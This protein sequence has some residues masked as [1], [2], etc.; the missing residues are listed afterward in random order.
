ME[1]Q[2]K[3]Y[4]T[5]YTKSIWDR[6]TPDREGVDNFK[7]KVLCVKSWGKN[8]YSLSDANKACP[9][10]ETLLQLIIKEGNCPN[11]CTY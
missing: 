3:N 1:I 5:S 9:N 7:I 10:R 8:N 11:M 2:H 4:L 6:S